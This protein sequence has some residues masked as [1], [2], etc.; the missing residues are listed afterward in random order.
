MPD[1][2][3]GRREAQTQGQVGDCKAIGIRK[4]MPH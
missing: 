1:E 2:F 3:H 4:K